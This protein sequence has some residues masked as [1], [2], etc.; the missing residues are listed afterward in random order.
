MIIKSRGPDFGAYLSATKGPQIPFKDLYDAGLLDFFVT[1]GCQEAEYYSSIKNI[2]WARE[3]GCKCVGSY[4]WH[5]PLGLPAYWVEVYSAAIRFENPDFIALDMEDSYGLSDWEITTNAEKVCEGLTKNFPNLKL[6]I[7]TNADYINGHCP[8]FNRSINK[9]GRWVACWPGII[10]TG[11][12]RYLSFVEI[13]Q[14]PLS[15]WKV[16][17]PDGWT[18]YDIWQNN[19]WA[20]PEG[21]GWPFDHQY[22]WNASP[23]TIEQIMGKEDVPMGTYKTYVKNADKGHFVWLSSEDKQIDMQGVCS[24]TDTIFLR[25]VSQVTGNMTVSKDGAFPIWTDRATKPVV[26]VV[27][28]DQNLFWNKEIDLNKFGARTMWENETLRAILDQ[29]HVSTITQAEWDA[30]KLNITAGEGWHK[31]GGLCLFMSTTINP[32]HGSKIGGA[33]QQAIVDD[34]LKSLTTLMQGGYIPTVK[35]YVMA[36]WDWYKDYAADTGWKPAK[37]IEDKQIAGLG[38]A[39]VWGQSATGLMTEVPMAMPYATLSEVWQNIPAD[40]Y[41]YPI[42]LT[43][44]DFQFFVFSFNRLLASNMFYAGNNPTPVT[45]GMWCD[46]ADNMGLGAVVTPPPPVDPNVAEL[47]AKIKV[48][49]AEYQDALTKISSLMK[50]VSNLEAQAQTDQVEID[51]LKRKLIEWDVWLSQAPKSV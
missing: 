47:Q 28:M 7:Y 44:I 43:D 11:M 32:A 21:Y 23:L 29:W 18:G 1:K 2:Q 30:K 50:D 16:K 40:T 41:T 38:L 46:T 26:G 39:R 36:S 31:I 37:R 19:N 33:W 15:D 5:F 25:M 27:E 20:I 4:Y 22:D 9:Y 35:I 10:Y 3:A 8:T 6:Y 51:T 49:E 34:L 17:L 13:K 14:Y 42:A 45:C 48:M 24:G 12:D